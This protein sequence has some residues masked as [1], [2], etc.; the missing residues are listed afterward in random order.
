MGIKLLVKKDREKNEYRHY[1]QEYECFY[2]RLNISYGE[3]LCP[4]HPSY[5]VEI[6]NNSNEHIKS[7]TYMTGTSENT[8]GKAGRVDV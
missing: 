3:N 5:I 4:E 1:L 2:G 6:Y 7:I 8:F